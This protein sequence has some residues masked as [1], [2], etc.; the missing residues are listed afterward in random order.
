MGGAGA[1]QNGP[2]QG[3]YQGNKPQGGPGGMRPNNR[4]P[5]NNQ[6]G[7]ANRGPMNH[8][9]GPP[10]GGAPGMSGPQMNGGPPMQQ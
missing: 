4:A 5:Y 1:P 3:G 6:M 9:N 2:R 8:M 10:M 7:G